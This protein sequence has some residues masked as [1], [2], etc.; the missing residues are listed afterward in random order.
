MITSDKNNYYVRCDRCGKLQAF[1]SW[2]A[3]RHALFTEQW[4]E[5]LPIPPDHNRTK[6]HYCSI[7]CVYPSLK[8]S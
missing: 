2:E 8:K 4:L 7:T 3:W 5:L 6:Y 1:P